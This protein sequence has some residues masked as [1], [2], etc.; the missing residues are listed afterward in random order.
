MFISLHSYPDGEVYLI[1]IDK[2]HDFVRSDMDDRTEIDTGKNKYE[3]TETLEQIVNILDRYH[4][5]TWPHG[6]FND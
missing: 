2:I 3:V 5:M 4:R 6:N 1:N